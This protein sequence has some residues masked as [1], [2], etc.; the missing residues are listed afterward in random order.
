MFDCQSIENQNLP[1]VKKLENKIVFITGGDSG[2]GRECA[3]LAAQH[4]AKVAIADL[5]E[6]GS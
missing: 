4:G 2:I 5:E 6:S 1:T 3:L